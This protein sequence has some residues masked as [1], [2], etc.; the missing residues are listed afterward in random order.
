MRAAT[1]LLAC[2]P[3]A[4]LPARAQPTMAVVE[5][6][7][8]LLVLPGGGDVRHLPALLTDPGGPGQRPAVVI[9][10]DEAGIDGR[11]GRLADLAGRA[12]WIAVETDPEAVALDGSAVPPPPRPAR[13]ADWLRALQGVLADD[14]RVDSNRIA[15]VGL[16]A[17]GRAALHVAAGGSAGDAAPAFAA[18]AALYPGCAAL[19]AEGVGPPAAP[20]LVLIPGAEEAVAACAELDGDR[21]QL[22]RMEGATYAWD[23]TAGVG[24][25]GEMRR[26]SGGASAP[27]RPDAAAATAAEGALLRFLRDALGR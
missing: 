27:I 6:F 16:G 12:G 22:L 26:W 19:A 8:A 18:H 2:L 9:V 1:A 14:P 10:P 4:A 17:G 7:N 20:A 21:T 24:I 23:L 15:V 3:L 25:N 11:T 13:L 5:S